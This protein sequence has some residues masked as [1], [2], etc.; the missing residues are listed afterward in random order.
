MSKEC[1][2]YYYDSWN[3]CYSCNVRKA[4]GQDPEIDSDQVH[5][6]CWTYDHD[7]CP[8]YKVRNNSSSS[9]GCYL[10]TACVIAKGLPDDCDEL[11]TL[12]FFR[13]SFVKNMPCG[14]SDLAHY[15]LV[16]P[17][18]IKKI[19]QAENSKMIFEKIYSEL[20]LPCVELIKNR[21]LES[22]FDFYKTYSLKLEEKYL[23]GCAQ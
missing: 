16:A 12:R 13:E 21:R 5:K 15:N 23:K 22:A 19:E 9:G 3:R 6:F 17:M 10:T 2:Y 7:E 8:L 4:N 1:E 18:I 20:V 11:T 14:E